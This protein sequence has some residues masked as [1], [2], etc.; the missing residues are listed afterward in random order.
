VQ[1]NDKSITAKVAIAD[2]GADNGV[3][4]VIDTVLVPT[5]A[6]P[7][8]SVEST[9]SE[10]QP[11]RP[12]ASTTASDA[13]GSTSSK[14][15]GGNVGVVVAVVIILL[16][17]LAVAGF[18][19]KRKRSVGSPKTTSF[20]N[21]MY[22]SAQNGPTEAVV[23]DGNYSTIDSS[24]AAQDTPGYMDVAGTKGTTTTSLGGYMD[25]EGAPN[26]DDSDEEV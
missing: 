10:V 18:L 25:V 1:N 11:T 17:L 26:G 6:E 14:K 13:D 20:D 4:H 3:A 8:L 19:Y 23:E 22:D 12:A 2:V 5:V 24:H 15:E 9:L 7:T 16:L 21:P